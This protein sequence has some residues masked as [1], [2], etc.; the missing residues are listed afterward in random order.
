M[1]IKKWGMMYMQKRSAILSGIFSGGAVLLL[2]FAI[3]Y[4]LWIKIGSPQGLPGFFF[5]RAATIGDGICLPVLI[6]AAVVFN[7]LNKAFQSQG[8][9]VS[10]I[11]AMTASFIAVAIQASW[12][13]RDDT[14]LNWS[15]PIQH[16]FNVAG[17]YHS[18]FFVVMFGV[19]AYQL[20][21]I[22]FVLR[23]RQAEYLWF[24]KVTYGLFIFAGALF[25]FM[26][27]TDDYTQ[28]LSIPI[29]LSIVAAGIL[30]IV[31]IYIKTASGTRNKELVS[32]AIMGVISAYSVSLV[33]CMPEKGDI[34][35]ALGGGLC[36]CFI[37][38]V[39][40]LSVAQI[41]CKDFWTVIFYFG[42]LYRV[43][44]LTDGAELMCT[45][46]FLIVA[47]TICEESS[48]REARG[49]VVSLIAVEGYL[50]IN[51]FPVEIREINEVVNL[52][53]T[54]VINAL[55]NK[56]IRNYFTEV[57]T[58]EEK[59][60]ADQ[61]NSREFEKIKGKAYLQIVIGILAAIALILHWLFDIDGGMGFVIEAGIIHVPKGLVGIMFLVTG[62]LILF[63]TTQMRRYLAVKVATLIFSI[64]L[65][66]LLIGIIVVNIGALPFSVWS[67]LKSVMLEC[68]VW[69]CIGAGIL[70]AHGYYMNMV[71]LRGLPKKKS[72]IVMASIQLL[73]GIA[74]AF[75]ITVL[76]LCQQT[77]K[78]LILIGVA[79]VMGFIVI[80]FLHAKVFQYEHETIYVVGNNT[81]GG[82]A[83]DGLM[84]C[85]LVFFVICM[86][87]LYVSLSTN[88]IKSWLGAV[89]LIS[90][91][92]LPVEY[93]LRNNV[94]HIKRQRKVLA[95]HPE[96][97]DMW[98]VLHLCL[99][100]QSKQTVFATFPYVC[101]AVGAA[102]GKRRMKSM[103]RREILKDIYNTYI[104]ADDYE[105]EED[106][107][108]GDD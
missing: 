17:W 31:M 52:L 97:E 99:V 80:P 75:A 29:L 96:E 74:L 57:M 34:A 101:I 15:I 45:L 93:C 103:E 28:Y 94:G 100:R 89:F 21:R 40:N 4:F 44:A 58:A 3:M 23:S 49:R 2:G 66:G 82:I 39:H 38:R 19:I 76:I 73:C 108:E 36:A 5:Y 56:E 11:M 43:S 72:A 32:A 79:T 50:V 81:L 33:I 106:D 87:C 9:K 51:V 77:W 62:I 35:I 68:S 71:L 30:F 67:H 59:S 6:G 92:F 86:P 7:Q 70:S 104:D 1:I 16:H 64:F 41:I 25:L 105:S 24:E 18:L 91:A 53:F 13:I 98:N 102:Y 61:M 85:L 88:V 90:T 95:E 46:L 37:W 107:N 26:H 42:I 84:I 69:A 8:R 20:C 27:V 55:F 48:N 60:N 54:V 65:F 47:T 12:L 14:V 78:G 63:G 22:W 83:Q 10:S